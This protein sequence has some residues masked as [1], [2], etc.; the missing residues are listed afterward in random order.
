MAGIS[1]YTFTFI[2]LFDFSN[3]PHQKGLLFILVLQVGKKGSGVLV[4]CQQRVQLET[5]SCSVLLLQ[6][7]RFHLLFSCFYSS[8]AAIAFT[9]LE[10]G[11]WNGLECTLI[12][13][14]FPR[15]GFPVGLWWNP[16]MLAGTISFSFIRPQ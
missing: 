7:D 4:I 6:V 3:Q 1:Q 8:K 15:K 2:I 14:H 16:V 10:H 11:F 5:Q 13:N 12:N 9:F